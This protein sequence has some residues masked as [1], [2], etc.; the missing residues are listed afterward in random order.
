MNGQ[1]SLPVPGKAAYV[2]RQLQSRNH[3]CHWPGCTH[4]VPPA[5]WGCRPHWY[6]LPKHLRTAIWEAYVP[7]QEIRMDP[8]PQYLA[9]ARTVQRWIA[10]QESP[11][12]SLTVAPP[13]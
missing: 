9:V 3:T 7:G 1:E 8:S 11:P 13:L 6:T 2:R 5:M 12:C 10:A 4:Q